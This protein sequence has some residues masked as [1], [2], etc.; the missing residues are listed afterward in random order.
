MYVDYD[1]RRAEEKRLSELDMV[2]A[3]EVQAAVDTYVRVQ[4]RVDAVAKA[5]S[6]LRDRVRNLPD[7]EWSVR[8]F[9]ISTTPPRAGMGHLAKSAV[10]VTLTA[11]RKDN[12]HEDRLAR[13]GNGGHMSDDNVVVRHV[14]FP[15]HYLT[16]VD[17][18]EQARAEARREELR[19][20][21]YHLRDADKNLQSRREDLASLEAKYAADRA[22]IAE[23]EAVGVVAEVGD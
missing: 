14:E 22:R 3:M 18:L 6:S 5:V 10:R 21:K 9:N 20:L 16:S 17:W 15:L 1:K 2:S 23:L 8:D 19:W 7:Y 12:D 4:A 11:R 13:I